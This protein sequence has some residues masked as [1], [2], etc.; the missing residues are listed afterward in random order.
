MV[1]PIRV[2]GVSVLFAI[3]RCPRRELTVAQPGRTDLRKFNLRST[4]TL[5]TFWRGG[6]NF[7]VEASM[8]YIWVWESNRH[9]ESTSQSEPP[10]HRSRNETFTV[11]VLKWLRPACIKYGTAIRILGIYSGGVLPEAD[12]PHKP[13]G[14]VLE[15]TGRRP[16]L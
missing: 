6:C 12:R 9:R 2:S 5:N 13:N 15:F 10:S 1:S 8:A 11:R 4:L 7:T 3:T 16:R 14:T